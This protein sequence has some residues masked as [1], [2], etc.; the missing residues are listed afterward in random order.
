MPVVNLSKTDPNVAGAYVWSLMHY[1]DDMDLLISYMFS[2]LLSQHAAGDRS[3][4]SSSIQHPTDYTK[5]LV[6]FTNFIGGTSELHNALFSKQRGSM[7]NAPIDR[8][9]DGQISARVLLYCMKYNNGIPAAI[10]DV[11]KDII[12]PMINDG[13]LTEPYSEDNFLNNTWNKFKDVAH[14]WVSFMD[15]EADKDDNSLIMNT[16]FPFRSKALRDV[17]ATDDLAS[18]LLRAEMLRKICTRQKPKRRGPTK[19]ILDPISTYSLVLPWKG[20]K[21]G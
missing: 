19:T 5:M 18:F 8:H 4:G 20:V 7:I 2:I 13:E 3:D 11:F 10:H 17:G 21:L 14:I 1:P 12:F 6:E 16:A 9:F 15:F